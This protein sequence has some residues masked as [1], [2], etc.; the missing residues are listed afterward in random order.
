M[1]WRTLPLP[2]QRNDVSLGNLKNNASMYATQVNDGQITHYPYEIGSQIT[3]A[4]T[5]YQ[6]YQ[7]N[8]DEDMDGD[9]NRLFV[10]ICWLLSGCIR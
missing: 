8:M 2:T 5:H 6:Y 10:G 3:I 1:M 7:L 4:N 9:E